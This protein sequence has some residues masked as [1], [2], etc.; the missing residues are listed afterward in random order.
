MRQPHLILL[1]VVAVLV[2]QTTPIWGLVAVVL[3]V[4]C[5]ALHL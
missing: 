3:V 2:V 1:L 5:Q 4:C